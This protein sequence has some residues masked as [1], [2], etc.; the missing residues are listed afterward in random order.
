MK[1]SE[2]KIEPEL[3]MRVGINQE[4]VD[5]YAQA[6]LDGDKFPPII[7][8]HDGDDYHLA[9]GWKRYYAHKK[10]GLEI[11]DADVRMGTYEDAFDYALTQ[12]NYANGER[13]SPEDKRHALKLALEKERYTNQ[14]DRQLAKIL[15]VSHP[16]VAKVRKAAGKQPDTINVNRKGAKYTVQSPK[17]ASNEPAPTTPQYEPTEEDKI[18]EITSEMQD[19]V[20][21]NEKLQTR[22]AVV[23]MEATPEER[24]L[25]QAR[26]DEMEKTI[27]TL[28]ADNRVLKA[29]RDSFQRE[30]AELKKQVS[31]W[32]RR[33]K[34]L[35]KEAA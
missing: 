19:I 14:S 32:E 6:L 1:L 17:K 25:A 2:I 21:E 5:D 16:F 22:L 28:E 8:F 11:I 10:A 27:K 15:R 26:F 18:K 30:C 35:E 3:M 12:A 9:D 31:Y 34:K 33:A 13:Y 23:A 29:S 7:L 20:V 4:I 24:G